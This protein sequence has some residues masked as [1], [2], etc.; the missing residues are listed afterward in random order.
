MTALLLYL[1]ACLASVAALF[2][3]LIW[4]EWRE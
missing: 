3:D 1:F 2:G 4:M